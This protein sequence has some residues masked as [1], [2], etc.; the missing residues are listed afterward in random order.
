LIDF[1]DFGEK[2]KL[3]RLL[4]SRYFLMAEM[5]AISFVTILVPLL[6]VAELKFVRD[7]ILI[8]D[9]AVVQEEPLLSFPRIQSQK[10]K[11]GEL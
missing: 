1:S 11:N 2:V 3:E 8:L 4:F 5:S 7:N 9:L 10:S 6:I